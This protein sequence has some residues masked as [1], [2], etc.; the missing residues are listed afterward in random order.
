MSRASE[1]GRRN[2]NINSLAYQAQEL[3]ADLKEKELLQRGMR[4]QAKKQYGF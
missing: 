3:E 2:N 4:K 1:G